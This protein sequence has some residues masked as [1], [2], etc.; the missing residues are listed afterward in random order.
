MDLRVNNGMELILASASPRRSEILASL[1]VKFSVCVS[2][3]D[4]SSTLTSP[5]LLTEELAKRKGLAVAE[6]L[7]ERANGKIILSC[8]TVVYCDGEILGKPCDDSDARRMLRMLSGK[9]HRV[10]SGICLISDG[11]CRTASESTDVHFGT[12]SDADIDFMIE[13]GEARDKAGAYAVQGLA[14]MWIEGLS[15]DYFN[16]VGLPVNL[17]NRT[18][19]EHFG[20]DLRSFIR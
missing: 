11:V 12:L 20:A 7:C 5:E 9:A 1:G 13:T 8:D 6:L 15:G 14:S 18:L 19:R 4:E 2:D 16:V 10:V 3:A 17:L